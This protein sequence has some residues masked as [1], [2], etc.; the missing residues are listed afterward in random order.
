MPKSH[1]LIAAATAALLTAGGGSGTFAQTL[2]EFTPPPSETF[3]YHGYGSHPAEPGAPGTSTVVVIEGTA[4]YVCG[5][6]R[7]GAQAITGKDYTQGPGNSPF[8]DH[9]SSTCEVISGPLPCP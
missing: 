2:C 5:D 7:S 6:G 9:D 3:T 4:S 1:L 8:N